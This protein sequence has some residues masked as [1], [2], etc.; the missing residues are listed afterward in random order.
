M[1]IR[2]TG[3]HFDL[4]EAMR[5]HILEKIDAAIGKYFDGGSAVMWSW[6]TKARAI[7][8]IARCISRLDHIAFRRPGT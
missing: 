3:K 1:T 6:I 7:V 5:T 2:V 4:G 8:A